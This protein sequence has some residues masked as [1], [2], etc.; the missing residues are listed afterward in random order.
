MEKIQTV[1]GNEKITVY[2]AVSFRASRIRIEIINSNSVR[3]VLPSRIKNKEKI[4]IDFLREKSGW[5]RSKI[6]KVQ[7]RHTF[8]YSDE[9]KKVLIGKANQELPRLANMFA[10]KLGYNLKKITIRDQKTI[11]GSC[12]PRGNL[13]LNWHIV[14]LPQF[15]KEYVIIHELVHLAIPNHSKKFWQRLSVHLP[16]YDYCKQ[17]LRKF[18]FK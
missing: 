3:V 16:E 6:K 7:S 5:V 12:S 4:A 15:L 14:L 18:N 11:W 9:E 17:E 1:F 13:S 8:N 2:L 10:D